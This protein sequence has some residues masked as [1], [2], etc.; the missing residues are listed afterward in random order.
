MRRFSFFLPGRP[1]V[2]R[3]GW[4]RVQGYAKLRVV[5]AAGRHAAVA[6]Q[7]VRAEIPGGN[8]VMKAGHDFAIGPVVHGSTHASSQLDVVAVD[9]VVVA[10][11]VVAV[12]VVHVDGER[13]PSHSSGRVAPNTTVNKL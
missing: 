13:P 11:G 3:G 9:G 10:V 4:G 1:T 2:V 7:P 6:H 8:V 12:R 5:G